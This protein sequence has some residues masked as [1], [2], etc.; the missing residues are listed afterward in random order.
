M[1]LTEEDYKLIE[2]WSGKKIK[3]PP[4][5]E[6]PKDKKKEIKTIDVDELE[7]VLFDIL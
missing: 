7:E 3:R 4:K 2:K 5:L 1:A 6:N